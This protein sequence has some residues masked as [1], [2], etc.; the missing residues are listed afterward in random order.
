MFKLF[1]YIVS[2]GS[3]AVVDLFVLYVFVRCFDMWYVLAAILAFLIAFGVSFTLQKFW[4]FKD[5]SK[6]VTSQATIYFIVSTLN[7]GMNTLLVYLLVDYGHIH[8]IFS[9]I[10]ASG[11]LAISSYFIYSGFIFSEI[12]KKDNLQ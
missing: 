9:Q 6:K 1:R 5:V 7:L 8:Y 2:G 11:I 4:T 3:A 10:I 12:K